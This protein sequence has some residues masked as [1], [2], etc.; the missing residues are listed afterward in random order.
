MRLV[1]AFLGF[2]KDWRTFL[3][4]HHEWHALVIGVGDGISFQTVQTWQHSV[5]LKELHYYKT[6][7]GV[8]RLGL[9]ILV[10]ILVRWIVRG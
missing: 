1:G 7:V 10:A 5:L 8:G 9:I 2:L 4:D 3:S 6:G